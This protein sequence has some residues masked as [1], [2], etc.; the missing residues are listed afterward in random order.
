MIASADIWR[1]ANLLIKQHGD[2]APIHAAIRADEL[3]AAGDFEGLAVW[4]AIIRAIDELL[5]N[6][7]PTNARLH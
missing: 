3:L 5:A 7:A 6:E 2:D 4:K 1:T